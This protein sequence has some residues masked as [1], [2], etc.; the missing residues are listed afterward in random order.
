M[1]LL[2]SAF[3]FLRLPFFFTVSPI[4]PDFE[5]TQ[6][7][8]REFPVQSSGLVKVSNKFGHIRVAT[9]KENKVKIE[10]RIVVKASSEREAQ[11]IFNHIDL[12]FSHD[13]RLVKSITEI[14]PLFNS[15]FR[16]Y[17]ATDKDFSVNVVVMMPV[18]FD[19]ELDMEY[20]S[21]ELEEIAENADIILKNGTIN[22]QKVSNKAVMDLKL[23]NG[24]LG[25]LSS[26]ELSIENSNLNITK[27]QF[28]QIK[29][30]NSVVKI[31]K[32]KELKLRSQYDD[33]IINDVSQFKNSGQYD[34]IIIDKG[35]MVS[36]KTKESELIVKQLNGDTDLELEESEAYFQWITP[37]S[38]FMSLIGIGSE[39]KLNL[40]PKVNFKLDATGYEAG[41]YY[42]AHM[43]KDVD[44]D[45]MEFHRVIGTYKQ[46]SSK[47]MTQ[48]KATLQK[49][50]LKVLQK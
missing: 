24:E 11:K 10:T 9:W 5:F 15:R 12:N 37:K 25:H 47:S 31:D 40:D 48:I 28:L 3:L 33:Y 44:K 6:V 35:E 1:K 50:G 46:P 7:I 32:I 42:P 38:R 34:K 18:G 16:P 30:Q 29:S 36:M 41:I 43:V 13:D 19:L 17:T 4:G 45:N 2:F 20:G 26:G 49:G 23:V 39:F 22:I 21:I 27:S 8:K 14:N